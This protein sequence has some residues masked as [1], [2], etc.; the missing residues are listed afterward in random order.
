[1]NSP[2]DEA[3]GLD[4]WESGELGRSEEFARRAPPDLKAEI[5][6]ALELQMI[7]IRLQKQLLSDL[8][9]IADYRGIG[10]QPLV[11]EVLSRFARAEMSAIA[12]E[13]Q[14]QK[15]V[16]EAISNAGPLVTKAKQG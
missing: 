1:M 10:Y 3:E 11:R 8:K 13:L 4:P 6:D 16:R 15:Q 5:D 14:E 7:S 12:R 2:K 9:F